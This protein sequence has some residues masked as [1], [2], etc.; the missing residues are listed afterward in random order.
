MKIF[1]PSNNMMGLTSVEMRDPKIG[2]LRKVTNFSN[3]SIIRKTQFVEMLVGEDTYK[4]TPQDRDYLFLLAVGAISLNTMTMHVGCKFCGERMSE[5]VGIGEFDPIRLSRSVA[6]ER[7]YNIYGDVYHFHKLNVRDELAIE[8][9]ARDLPDEDYDNEFQDGMVATTFGWGIENE[10]I[11]RVRELD[12]SIYYAA[13]LFQNCDAHGVQVVKEFVCPKCGK[14]T[15]AFM[16]IT[17]DL[18][19]VDISR[20][21]TQYI[22]LNQ[23]VSMETFFEMTLP[24]KNLYVQAL[25]NKLKKK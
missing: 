6:A 16:P 15:K 9:R 4:I 5:Q 17:G 13:L 1:L 18:L 14:T 7:D 8:E 3:F 24:E 22:S 23:H 21:M 11:D 10:G 12:L 20:I 19:K 2:D 25:N